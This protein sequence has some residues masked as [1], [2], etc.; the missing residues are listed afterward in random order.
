MAS[1]KTIAKKNGRV[2]GTRVRS[3]AGAS[4]TRRGRG[5]TV[6]RR[7][8]RAN[9]TGEMIV[10]ER[11]GRGILMVRGER[12][13]VDADLAELY[14][15]TTKALNQ[16]V[17]RNAQR[18]PADFMFRLTRKEKEEVVTHCDHLAG[19]KFSPA[20]PHA[21]TEHGAIM[22][23]SVLNS[24]RASAVSVQV[25]RAFV[26]IRRL[27]AEHHELAERLEA[28]EAKSEARFGQV[29]EALQMLMAE[30]DEDEDPSKPKIGFRA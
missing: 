27:L 14:G 8:S 20:L 4:T 24:E 19:L 3:R 25:V 28:Y 7:G 17:K 6:S 11:V 30:P 5:R 1:G 26:K 21:F 9:K 10:R 16:A 23:A 12:V 15:V 18:F 2:K 22:A 29:Y 13:I